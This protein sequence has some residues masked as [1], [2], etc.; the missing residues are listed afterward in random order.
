MYEVLL[1]LCLAGDPG[2]CTAER[3][4]GGVTLE[5]C[6]AAATALAA[7]AKAEPQS[8]P[9]VPQG[10]EPGFTVTEIAPG[11][12]VHKGAHAEAAPGNR[13]DLANIGFV[14]GSEAVA[15]I[16]AGGSAA[17]GRD[18]L[19]AVRRETDLPVRWLIL[20]HMHPDHV[21]GAPVLVEAGATVVGHARLAR[22]LAARRETYMAA[23]AALIGPVF[24]GSGIPAEVIPVEREREIDLGGRALVL[25]A[26]P[27]AH[28]D[29]DLT[30]LDRGT[31]TL[32]LGDL[33]FMGHLPALDGSL[34]GWIDVLG[35]LSGREAARAVAGH[36]PVSAPWPG[37]AAAMRA[38][39]GA[40]A[41]EVR[42]AIAEGVPIGRAAERVGGEMTAGWL[43]ADAFHGRN[44]LAAFQELEWE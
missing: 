9:C 40:L 32:F 26:H 13:G 20:T 12:F 25:Q 44:V 27:T 4:P 41:A 36:G 16:D 37:A 8:W 30:V 35:A 29:N 18:L 3:H 43:L 31:G 19:E 24:E 10:P 38:Y 5:A 42:S 15:V 14:V 17:V 1:T 23:N 7:A 28:T 39:L 33:L 6:R 34:I 22:A 21:L 2:R 11:V